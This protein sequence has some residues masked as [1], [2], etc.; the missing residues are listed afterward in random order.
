MY[1]NIISGEGT[2]PLQCLQTC[3]LFMFRKRIMITTKQKA[4]S[5]P[6]TMI[7]RWQLGPRVRQSTRC[8]HK[9]VEL[10]IIFFYTI[11]LTLCHMQCY[12]SNENIKSALSVYLQAGEKLLCL[13][14]S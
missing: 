10:I 13:I 7:T 14:F 3:F 9:S 4:N 11:R 8:H 1:H 6:S 5:T 12:I 2:V